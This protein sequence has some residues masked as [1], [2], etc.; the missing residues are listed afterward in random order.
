MTAPKQ[1]FSY[2]ARTKVIIVAV[3]AVAIGGFVLAG[4]TANTDNPDA[5]AVSGDGDDVGGAGATAELGR[6]VERVL[7]R[8]GAESVLQQSEIV[9][10]L[11]PGWVAELVY[12]PDDGD[13]VVLPADEID[14]V[15]ELDQF[16][17]V[18]G[19]DK[20]LERL[21]SNDQCVIATIWSRVE[22]RAASERVV[23]WC[24]SVV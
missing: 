5:V 3:L 24:F 14:E 22:G 20:T 17:Y 21:T 10:D 12:A 16:T 11:E 13:A 1:T 23:Q 6:G 8:V 9:L 19:P 4:L 2:P 15:P 18:P 7:P